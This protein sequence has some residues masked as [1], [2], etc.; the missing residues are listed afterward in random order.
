MPAGGCQTTA[1]SIASGAP[2]SGQTRTVSPGRCRVKAAI[3]AGAL[4][5]VLE[6]RIAMIA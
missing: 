1:N 2:M 5:A 3:Q 6:N 4:S